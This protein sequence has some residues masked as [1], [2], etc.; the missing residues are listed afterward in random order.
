LGKIFSSKV[1]ATN[2]SYWQFSK[3]SSTF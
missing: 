2:M 1:P 3:M